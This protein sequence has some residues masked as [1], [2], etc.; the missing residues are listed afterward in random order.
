MNSST[1]TTAAT[2]PTPAREGRVRTEPGP[3]FAPTVAPHRRRHG[4]DLALAPGRSTV[5]QHVPPAETGTSTGTST[6]AVPPY[7]Q[8]YLP[9]IGE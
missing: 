4:D 2:S 3:G 7:V 6:A 5:D 8:R 1:P 9:L